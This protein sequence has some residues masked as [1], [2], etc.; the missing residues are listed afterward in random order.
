MTAPTY[1]PHAGRLSARDTAALVTVITK[2]TES[3]GAHVADGLVKASKPASSPTHHLFE[4]DDTKAGHLYRL[5]QA[6][7]LIQSID[8]RFTEDSEPVRAFP[9][10]R[11]GSER[12]HVPMMKVLS[13][14]EMTAALL[15]E[16]KHEAAEWARRY[17][18]LQTVSELKGVF[19]EIRRI[20]A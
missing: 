5:E 2:L 6:R 12:H 15:E 8:I 18:R 19:R 1:Q 9:S 17:D 13:S 3:D 11:F 10:V 4:W 16:A 14:K 20:K 7:R